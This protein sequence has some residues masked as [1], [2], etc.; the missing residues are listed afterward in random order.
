MISWRHVTQW[1]SPLFWVLLGMLGGLGLFLPVLLH[2][3]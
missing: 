2:G 1:V 3:R